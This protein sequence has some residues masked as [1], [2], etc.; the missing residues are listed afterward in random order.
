MRLIDADAVSERLEAAGVDCFMSKQ[1]DAAKGA[2]I[3]KKALGVFPTID[4]V[5]VVRCTDC[6]FNGQV[7]DEV[8]WCDWWN[9]PRD[10]NEDGFC[11]HGE[12][13]EN[14]KNGL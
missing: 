2:F 3:A 10:E 12:R 5:P 8:G 11:S 1:F 14:N 13:K 4:A 6:A 7:T 9:R